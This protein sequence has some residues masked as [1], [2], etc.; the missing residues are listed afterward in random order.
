MDSVPGFVRQQWVFNIPT[1]LY[2]AVTDLNSA[3]LGLGGK[4]HF[5]ILLNR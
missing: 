1:P 3:P 2:N 4:Y 5:I